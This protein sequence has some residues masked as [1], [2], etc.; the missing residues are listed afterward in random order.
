[1]DSNTTATTSCCFKMK[2]F[3]QFIKKI[4]L[5]SKLLFCI[6]TCSKRSACA[7]NCAQND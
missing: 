3:H 6:T 7:N 4:Y 2:D 1:M 5:C